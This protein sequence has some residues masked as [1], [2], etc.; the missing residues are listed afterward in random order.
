M[1][2]IHDGAAQLARV[3]ILLA[4]L[5]SSADAR[6]WEDV[7]AVSIYAQSHVD[8]AR[9][10]YS[11]EDDPLS[12]IPS[13]P[14]LG[15]SMAPSDAPSSVPSAYRTETALEQQQQQES[16]GQTTTNEKCLDMGSPYNI[17]RIDSAGVETLISIR[18][19]G[20]DSATESSYSTKSTTPSLSEAGWKLAQTHKIYAC[21][22]RRVMK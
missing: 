1:S 21:H 4:L 19:V 17:K 5:R 18:Q 11:L 12:P 13:Y 6:T 7:I 2:L 16:E 20:A 14:S 9:L 22:I 8:I 10:Q 3:V 15:D